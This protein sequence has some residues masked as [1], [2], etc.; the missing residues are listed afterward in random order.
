MKPTVSVIIVS[1]NTRELT[2][3]CLAA[4][5]PELGSM[6]SEIFVI[7]NCSTPTDQSRPSRF[8]FQT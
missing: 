5:V 7:D 4:L 6:G 2:L 8:G 1:Y 3:K